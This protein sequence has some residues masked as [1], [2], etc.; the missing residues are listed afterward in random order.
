[1][2]PAGRRGGIGR[3]IMR[4]LEDAAR[5]NGR[6]LLTLDTLSGGAG[7]ALYRAEGWQI[8]GRIPGF[9]RAADGVGQDTTFF[10]K[11]LA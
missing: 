2:H 4:R 11:P 6:T 1:M 10:W 9:S 5:A 8:V 7:E 3:Q